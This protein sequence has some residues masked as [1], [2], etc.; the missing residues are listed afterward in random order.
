MFLLILYNLKED[1]IIANLAIT[2]RSSLPELDFQASLV[3]SL[4]FVVS[5]WI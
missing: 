5:M 2:L 4:N 1:E 3:S